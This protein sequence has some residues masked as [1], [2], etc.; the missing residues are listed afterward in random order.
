MAKLGMVTVA[1]LAQTWVGA[2]VL[3]ATADKVL[4]VGLIL[5]FRP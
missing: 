3:L 1:I 5:Q 4:R 2:L